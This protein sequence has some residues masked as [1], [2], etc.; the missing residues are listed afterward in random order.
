M[1]NQFA[2]PPINPLISV[3]PLVTPQAGRDASNVPAALVNL[4]NGTIIEGFVVNRDPQNNPIL[5]TPLGDVLIKSDIFLKTGSVVVFRVDATQTSRARILTIDGLTPSDYAAQQTRIPLDDTIEQTLQSPAPASAGT[6][7]ATPQKPPAPVV[8]HAV[9]L[10]PAPEGKPATIQGQ[11]LPVIPETSPLPLVLTKLQTGAQLKITLLK[12][13]LPAAIPATGKPVHI[14]PQPVAQAPLSSP[15]TYVASPTT[16]GTTPAV[17]F[18]VPEAPKPVTA[19]FTPATIPM[20][21]ATPAVVTVPPPV[22]VI[23]NPQASAI[24]LSPPIP[25]PPLTKPDVPVPPVVTTYVPPLT[26]PALPASAPVITPHIVQPSAVPAQH[27]PPVQT[28]APPPSVKQSVPIVPAPAAGAPRT[29]SA[30]LPTGH[31]AIVIG[32]ERDGAT[33]LHTRFGTLKTFLPQPLPT[34][35]QL[36]VRAE[37]E[38]TTAPIPATTTPLS[39]SMESVTSLA[40]EWKQLSDTVQWLQQHDPTL[41]NAL[42]QRLPGIGPKLTSGIL[43]FLAAVKGGDI[44]QWL[45]TR[46]TDELEKKAPELLARLRGDMNQMQQLVAETPGRQWSIAMLPMFVEGQLEQARLFFRQE[47]AAEGETGKKGGRQ[48]RF[49]LEVDLSHL[50]NLQ[51]DG[52]VRDGTQKRVF[53]LIIRSARHL[54]G[55]VTATI[56]ELF[57]NAL[58][59]TGYAGHLTFQQ[60]SQYFVRPLASFTNDS[61]GTQP[62]LA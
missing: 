31:T 61:S 28:F 8:L 58:K 43:F 30:L 19:G 20:S 35:T 55:E 49:I 42:T 53:D 59:T 29:V 4:A 39:E 24:A 48:H 50:G 3:Q 17:V 2:A 51:F 7:A 52:F 57:D 13:D 16:A 12:V 45:G 23:T 36:V 11:S 62:I 41:F 6:T 26:Q 14:S 33:V 5:R 37:P 9:L 38:S 18:P 25:S 54:P 32:H 1:A 46:V 21:P 47:D 15:H 27:V 44:R 60:G 56:L 34:G 10:A 22:A 40:R